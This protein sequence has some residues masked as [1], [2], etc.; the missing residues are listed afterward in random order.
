MQEQRKL[1]QINRN[2]KVAKSSEKLVEKLSEKLTEI[3]AKINNVE[4]ENGFEEDEED[5]DVEMECNYVYLDRLKRRAI[6]LY[7]KIQ[8]VC[9]I[10]TQW[11]NK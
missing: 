3:I 1:I 11:I 9:I 7:N 10:D 2:R 6:I 5:A 8:E 4:Q